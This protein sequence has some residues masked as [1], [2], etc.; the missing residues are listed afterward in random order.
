[1]ASSKLISTPFARNTMAPKNEG[2]MYKKCCNYSTRCNQNVNTL[3]ENLLHVLV[4]LQTVECRNTSRKICLSQTLFYFLCI[5]T[6]H[7]LKCSQFYSFEFLEIKLRMVNSK[8][9][10]YTDF[11]FKILLPRL[12]YHISGSHICSKLIA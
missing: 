5:S 3:A 4:G 12:N 10:D 8:V 7:N 9:S 11:S 1:M 6:S 2:A